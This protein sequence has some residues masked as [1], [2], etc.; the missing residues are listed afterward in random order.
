MSV[1]VLSV[2]SVVAF[3]VCCRFLMKAIVTPLPAVSVTML[4]KKSAMR[5]RK[6]YCIFA[7]ALLTTTFLYSLVVSVVQVYTTL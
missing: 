7:W 3:C 1:M 4:Y 2:L 6:V 5:V